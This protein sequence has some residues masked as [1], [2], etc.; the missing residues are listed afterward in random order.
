VVLLQQEGGKDVIS[1]DNK[2]AVFDNEG[3][4][5][6]SGSTRNLGNAVKDACAAI[7]KDVREKGL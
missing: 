1:K 3:D 2:F 5:I 7:T 4:S 6:A